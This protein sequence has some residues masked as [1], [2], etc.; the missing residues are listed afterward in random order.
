MKAYLL[1]FSFLL[2][3]FANGIAQN[4][5]LPC[6]SKDG[7]FKAEFN[8]MGTKMNG[9]LAVKQKSNHVLHVAFTSPMGNNLLEMKWRNGK[10]KRKYSI[11][12]LKNKKLFNMLSE[13]ILLLFGYQQYDKSFEDLGDKWS[14]NK[15]TLIPKFDSNGKLLSFKVRT[16]RHRPSKTV[17]YQYE[18]LCVSELSVNHQGFP[19]SI[20]LEP[21]EKK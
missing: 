12:K 9:F 18:K 3:A 13:D 16:R 20:I 19:F 11:K 5:Q 4:N 14:W 8:L 7:F 10:W 21:L 6:I 1:I 15:K 17:K 2:S